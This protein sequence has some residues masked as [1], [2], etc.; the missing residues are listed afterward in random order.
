MVDQPKLKKFV[1]KRKIGHK[2]PDL[3]LEVSVDAADAAAVA[4][5]REQV[6]FYV[7]QHEGAAGTPPEYEMLSFEDGVRVEA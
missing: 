5:A 7:G 1:V 2:K 6:A 3:M 4:K